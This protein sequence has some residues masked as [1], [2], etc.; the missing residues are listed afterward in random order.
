MKHCF[1]VLKGRE[2]FGVDYN[3]ITCAMRHHSAA[4]NMKMIKT[5]REFLGEG[6][7]AADLAGAESLYPM[8]EFME[9]CLEKR[10]DLGCRLQFMPA[11]AAVIKIFAM[12]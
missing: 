4:D 6:V 1:A 7:C 9:F 3:V 2:D 11:S 12:P 5:A 8:S 10:K